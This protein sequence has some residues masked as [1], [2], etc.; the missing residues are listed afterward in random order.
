MYQNTVSITREAQSSVR[1]AKGKKT[2]L[3]DGWAW[4]LGHW[5][6]MPTSWKK[7]R[8]KSEIGPRSVFS[9]VELGMKF[10]PPAWVPLTGYP[11]RKRGPR[12]YSV[13]VLPM[14]QC[15]P[16]SPRRHPGFSQVTA[17]MSS[18]PSSYWS[19]RPS[20]CRGDTTWPAIISELERGHA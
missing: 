19:S 11:Q 8:E 10:I 1:A 4:R 2:T 9:R 17:D 13:P 5:C 14:P 6:E 18:R 7:G 3:K 20:R 15:P 16:A 12:A